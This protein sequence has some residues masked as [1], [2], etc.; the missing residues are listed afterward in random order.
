[1]DELN[2]QSHRDLGD[3]KNLT[4]ARGVNW[5]QN[6]APNLGAMIVNG[7]HLELHVSLILVIRNQNC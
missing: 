3:L 4:G 2:D 7:H 1:M 6:E 5:S